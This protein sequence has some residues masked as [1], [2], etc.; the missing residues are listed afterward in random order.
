M[1]KIYGSKNFLKIKKKMFLYFSL[2]L[3]T[4]KLMG[5]KDFKRLLILLKCI[6]LYSELILVLGLGSHPGPRQIHTFFG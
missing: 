2:I 3:E 1:L 4:Q 6:E 5:V